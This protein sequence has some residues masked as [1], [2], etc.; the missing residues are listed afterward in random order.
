MPIDP[1]TPL[2]LL[3][4]SRE[5]EGRFRSILS[6]RCG[7]VRRTVLVRVPKNKVSKFLSDPWSGEAEV[8]VS[9]A[10]GQMKGVIE[11]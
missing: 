7:F 5:D 4:P 6:C 1:E 8:V 3:L 11:W 10:I 2:P 9:G